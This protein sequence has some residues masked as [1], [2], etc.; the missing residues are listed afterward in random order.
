MLGTELEYSVALCLVN[1]PRLVQT[2]HIDPKWFTDPKL[3]K[4]VRFIVGNNGYFNNYID[5]RQQFSQQNPAVLSDEDWRVLA[6]SDSLK[7]DFTGYLYELRK[8]YIRKQITILAA[9]LQYDPNS[10]NIDKMTKLFQ[11]ASDPLESTEISTN[12]LIQKVDTK[13]KHSVSDGIL[14]YPIVD[15]IFNHGIHSDQLIVIGARP[16]V[17][18]TSFGINLIINALGRNQDMVIDLF[19]LEMSKLDIFERMLSIASGVEYAKFFNPK[20]AMNDKE[21]SNVQLSERVFSEYDFKLYDDKTKIEEISQKIT[22]RS[23]QSKPGHYL[24]VIDYLQLISSGIKDRRQDIE[25]ITRRLKIM[26]SSLHIPIILFSQL[27]R[28]VEYREN[29][30]PMLS[31]LRE[32]GSIEQDANVVGFLHRVGDPQ[33]IDELI[34]SI[35]KN[36]EGSLGSV[37]LMF[38]KNTQRIKIKM[39]G[40]D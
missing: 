23:E 18:K 9:K 40:T 7:V 37:P 10:K 11:Q 19:S 12:D 31:D 6:N 32:T 20:E 28:S 26:T 16:S 27:N 22:Q 39:L 35:R 1:Y 34:F 15:N 2:N 29:K 8:T 24:A 33:E 13:M 21:K 14:T 4:I 30:T 3:S 17:G 25:N 5:F 38:R 36:R